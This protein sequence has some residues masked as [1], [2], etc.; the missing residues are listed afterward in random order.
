MRCFGALPLGMRLLVTAGMRSQVLADFERYAFHLLLVSCVA[1]ED[2]PAL[3]RRVLG[4]S[5]REV[6]ARAAPLLAT[7]QARVVRS[8]V[9]ARAEDVHRCVLESSR[10]GQARGR[11]AV[12]VRRSVPA[13]RAAIADE[14][15]AHSSTALH[16]SSA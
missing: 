3:P 7:A 12:W 2:G 9:E 15:P 1:A 5:P 13:A 10:F 16:I 14:V 11:V 6:F 4:P 8:F